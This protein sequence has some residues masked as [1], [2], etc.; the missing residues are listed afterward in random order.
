[1]AASIAAS[2]AGK[3]SSPV[4]SQLNVELDSAM[5]DVLRWFMVADFQPDSQPVGKE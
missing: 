1:L 4:Q 3:T 2:I 5:I